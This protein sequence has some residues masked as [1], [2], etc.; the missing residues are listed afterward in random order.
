MSQIRWYFHTVWRIL[1]SPTQFFQSMPVAGGMSGPLAFALVTHWVG[2]S[3]EFIWTAVFG[4]GAGT[5][6]KKLMKLFIEKGGRWSGEEDY[7]YY[8]QKLPWI[9]EDDRLSDI[10]WGLGTIV[11]DPFSTVLSIL[12][13][14]FFVW[15]GARILVSPARAG[16]L[17]EITFESVVRVISY[18][19][20]PSLFLGLPLLGG[21]ISSLYVLVITVIGVR[22]IYRVKPGRALAIVLFPK[23]LFFGIISMGLI[24]IVFVFF[25]FMTSFM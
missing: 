15:L 10:Y 1:S 19:L 13:T 17:Q 7:T 12:F 23:L 25:K 2:S 24:L 11:L 16:D 21:M 20:T 5:S 8:Y 14:A 6:F 3:I 22:E 4:I 9:A 18:G